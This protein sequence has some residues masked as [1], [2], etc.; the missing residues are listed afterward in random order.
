LASKEDK[1]F[2]LVMWVIWA[3]VMF[4]VFGL[5]WVPSDLK[6]YTES[7]FSGVSVPGPFQI[8]L[9]FYIVGWPV[10]GWLILDK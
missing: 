10:F 9:L 6:V 5:K 1:S 4:C 8:I 3:V 7:G 2:F